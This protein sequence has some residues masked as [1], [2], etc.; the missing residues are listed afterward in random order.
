MICSGR[1]LPAKAADDL[2]I[3]N[4]FRNCGISDTGGCLCVAYQTQAV[5]CAWWSKTKFLLTQRQQRIV[6]GN[7]Q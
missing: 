5:F 6:A 3:G 4:L 2:A 7:Q 1:M